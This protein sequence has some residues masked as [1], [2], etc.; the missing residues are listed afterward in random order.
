M[1]EN[2]NQS[3]QLQDFEEFRSIVIQSLQSEV[4]SSEN[5]KQI[6]IQS[7]V[8]LKDKMNEYQQ[9]IVQQMQRS[10]TS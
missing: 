2:T 3:L 5:D 9:K 1:N 6:L 7:L 8:Y 10:H 4:P